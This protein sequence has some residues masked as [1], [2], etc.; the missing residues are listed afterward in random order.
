MKIDWPLVISVVIP[1]LTLVLGAVL[2]RLIERR[3]K[4]TT[5][6]GHASV[7]EVHPATGVAQHVHTHSIVVTNVGGKAANNVRLSHL[8]LPDFYIWPA[9]PHAVEEVPQGGRDIVIPVMVP[10]QQ[11]TV[12]YLYFPPTTWNLI[13]AGVRSDE[14]FAKVLNMLPTRQFSKPINYL[15]FFLMLVGT[16]TVLYLIIL[17]VIWL[18]SFL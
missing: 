1:L 8:Q 16:I 3:A 9:V 11:I 10:G 6:L 4:L 2:N 13:N 15:I 14:G 7:F 18:F 12:S 5:Y 17:L